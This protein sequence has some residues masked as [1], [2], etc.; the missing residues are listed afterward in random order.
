MGEKLH[1][2]LPYVKAEV[3]WAVRHE[4]ALTLEDVLARRTRSLI[5]DAAA[6]MEIAVASAA[7]M[8]RE[9][10]LG[11]QWQQQQV[12]EFK[13]VAGGYLPD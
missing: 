9:L 6:S 13:Q 8:A 7:L 4:M 11:P 5:L 10:G 12:S 3:V 1:D 2:H